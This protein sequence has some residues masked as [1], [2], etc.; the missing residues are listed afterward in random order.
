M[1]LRQLLRGGPYGKDEVGCVCVHVQV[2]C[3]CMCALVRVCWET[4]PSTTEQ[5]LA[6][7]V[8]LAPQDGTVY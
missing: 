3:V 1:K 6:L 5:T 4:V 7:R 2:C 8:S